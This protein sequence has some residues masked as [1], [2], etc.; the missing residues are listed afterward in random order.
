MR[1]RIL[2]M[3]IVFALAIGAAFASNI[4]SGYA[5]IYSDKN[6]GA[7]CPQISGCTST[8]QTNLCTVEATGYANSTC[9]EDVTAYKVP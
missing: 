4:K 5:P 9:T 1:K 2:L 7:P 8:P 6:G 3:S